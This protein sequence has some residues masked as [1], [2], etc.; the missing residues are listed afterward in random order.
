[1]SSLSESLPMENS[2]N[3]N[4]SNKLVTRQYLEPTGKSK[5]NEFL[6]LDKK[7]GKNL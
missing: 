3:S 6:N 5:I 4:N 7:N 1:M 2:V